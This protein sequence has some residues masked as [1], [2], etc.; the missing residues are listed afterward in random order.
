MGTNRFR[1][2]NSGSIGLILFVQV[3]YATMLIWLL[4]KFLKIVSRFNLSKLRFSI[5][6]AYVFGCA[7]M[8]Y[9]PEKSG[10]VMANFGNVWQCSA[11]YVIMKKLINMN[12]RVLRC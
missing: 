12:T 5:V 8:L 4:S 10:N 3:L 9:E 11:K 6:L 1:S 7:K 2:T